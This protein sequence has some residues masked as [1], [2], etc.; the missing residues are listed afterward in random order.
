MKGLWVNF[1]MLFTNK[2]LIM[3]FSIV[4]KFITTSNSLIYLVSISI[5]SPNINYIK[6]KIVCQIN[7]FKK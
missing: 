4:N 5:L 2:I 1:V 6:A 7:F 3:P